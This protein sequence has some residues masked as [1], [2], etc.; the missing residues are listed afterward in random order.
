MNFNPLNSS[1]TTL[2]EL[3][4]HRG[5]SDNTGVHFIN[6]IHKEEFV[7]YRQLYRHALQLL[8][9]FQLHGLRPKDEIV[10]Q[11]D[12]NK[13]FLH[14]F[15]ACILGGFRPVPVAVARHE[16]NYNK[17]RKIIGHLHKPYLLT[18]SELMALKKNEEAGLQALFSGMTYDSVICMD[19]VHLS[20]KA[21]KPHA[22]QPGDIAFIQFSSGSTGDPKGVA[23]THQNIL[24]NVR[25][26]LKSSATLAQETLLTWMPLTHDMGLIGFH[27]NPAALGSNHWIMPTELF[28]R[29]PMLWL[30]K[31]H[32]HR[33]NITAAPSSG[34][35]HLLQK[36]KGEMIDLSCVR[37][38]L[39][40]AEPI[41]ARLCRHFLETLH[42]Y[43]LQPETM[44]P[45][46]G[47]A[48]ATLAVSFPVP[49]KVFTSIHVRPDSLRLFEKIIFTDDPSRAIELV[50]VGNCISC[51]NVQVV[52]EQG[53]VLPE[54]HT[55][56]IFLK[57]ENITAGYYNNAAATQAAFQ[58]GW[59]NTQDTGFMWKGELYIT[60]RVKEL[61]FHKGSNIYPQDIEAVARSAEENLEAV[62]CGIQNEDERTD[63]IILFV[64]YRKE[65]GTFLDLANKLKRQVASKLGIEVDHVIPVKKI[66]LTSS[67]KIKRFEL[68]DNYR[69][70]IYDEVIGA[71]N[72]KQDPSQAEQ[73]IVE[74]LSKRLNIDRHSVNAHVSFADLGV[75]SLMAVEFAQALEA[76]F[77]IHL[78][79]TI[80]WKYPNAKTLA[81]CIAGE[82]NSSQVTINATQQEAGLI[83]IVGMACRFPQANDTAAFWQL[84]RQGVDCISKVPA[85]RWTQAMQQSIEQ[86]A[87]RHT[88]EYGGYLSQVD[89][90][91]PGFFGISPAEAVHMDPQQRLLMEVSW[92]ALEDAGIP[93]HD[94]SGKEAGVFIG[95]SSNDYGRLASQQL[96][97]YT[98]TGNAFSI[99]ANR[100]SYFFNFQGP[101]VAI[102]TACSSSLV[103]VHQACQSLQSGESSICLAG[104]INLLLSPALSMVFSENRML[105]KDGRCKTFDAGADGYVRGEG[106]GIVVLKKLQDAEKDGDRILAVIRGSA[107]NQDGHSNGLTAP[108]PQAQKAVIQKAMRAANVK[109]ADI[110]YVE[111]HGTGTPL[112][113]PI[114]LNTLIE[115]FGEGRSQADPCYIGSVKTN[116]GHLEAAAGIAGL[117][118][119]I[120]LLQHQQ[121]PPHLHLRSMN[122]HIA[123]ASSI[124][125]PQQLIAWAT[126][127]KRMG[128]V[129]SFGFGGTNAHVIVE[130]APEKKLEHNY[131]PWPVHLFVL[132]ATTSTALY[133]LAVSNAKELLQTGN[134]FHDICYTSLVGRT[135]F[136][137]RLAIVA[138]SKEDLV[139][140]L[141]DFLHN[142]DHRQ[143]VKGRAGQVLHDDHNL[144]HHS[145]NNPEADHETILQ[146]LAQSYVQGIPVD[147]KKIYPHHLFRKVSLP[148][149]PFKRER[150]WIEEPVSPVSISV[151]N[152][153]NAHPL[154]GPELNLAP[155][156]EMRFANTT[157]L[158]PEY[159]NHH[160]VYGKVI[161]PASAYIE[162]AL[163]AGA[164]KYAGNLCIENIV[165]EK[166]M[167][168]QAE[169]KQPVQFILSAENNSTASFQLYTE[170]SGPASWQLHCS[171][172]LLKYEPK[173]DV[174]AD[175]NVFR[176]NSEEIPVDALYDSFAAAGITYGADFRAM[177]QVFKGN[178]EALT[179]II[180][181]STLMPHAD[182][183]C[184]HPVL[185]DACFQAIA[186]IVNDQGNS[187]WMPDSIGK[188]IYCN[189]IQTPAW[190][191]ARLR[192]EKNGYDICQ[193]NLSVYDDHGKLCIEVQDL[194]IKKI[195]LA[196][197]F[198]S[199]EDDVA[200]WLYN[201]AW[202]PVPQLQ[203]EVRAL[204]SQMEPEQYA[205]L[206]NTLDK[207][208]VHFMIQALSELGC[209]FHKGAVIRP[210]LFEALK[211]NQ[212]HAR[213]L[214]RMLQ[215][216]EEE[217][218]IEM[219]A[220]EWKVIRAV[221]ATKPGDL[222]KQLAEKFPA[223]KEELSLFGR[224]ASQIAAVLKKETDAL[225]ILFP[226][227]DISGL[228]AFYGESPVA[229]Y[230][231]TLAA[232]AVASFLCQLPAAR[233]INILEIGAGTGATTAAILPHL[234]GREV[235]YCFTDISSLFLQKAQQKFKPYPFISYKTLDIETDPAVAGSEGGE[236]DIIIAAN[237]LHATKDV[238]QSLKHIHSL[239]SCNGL[240][241]LV[242]ITARQ[243]WL[244]LVFGLTDGWWRFE[245][246][247]LRPSHPL[248]T[249]NQ[250]KN[251]L[252]H[253]GFRSVDDLATDKNDTS[254]IGQ[255]VFV[256]HKPEVQ[257]AGKEHW[258]LL[259]DDKGMAIALSQLLCAKQID[260]TLVF[261][262]GEYKQT[263]QDLNSKSIAVKVIDMRALRTLAVTDEADVMQ[264]A[265]LRLC[266]D[267][268][269]LLH[270]LVS[271]KACTLC[272]IT[273]GSQYINDAMNVEGLA[274]SCLA[275]MQKVIAL[276]HPE[277]QCRLIDMGAE[278]YEQEAADLLFELLHHHQPGITAIRKS[279]A[280]S[281]ELIKAQAPSKPC[282]LRKGVYLITGGS[283]GLGITAA[284]KL[285]EKGAS[286]LVLVSRNISRHSQALEELKN[287][288]VQ[289][290][291]A[292]ADVTVKEDL[293]RVLDDIRQT[294]I[295]LRG[296]IH[297]AGILDDGILLHQRTDQFGAV[298]KPKVMGAWN[299]HQLTKNI[300]LDHFILFS[301][302]TALFGSPGQSSHCAANAFLDALAFYRNANG[303]PALSLNWGLWSQTGIVAGD[304][305]ER[306]V[307]KFNWI[308]SIPTTEG[309]DLFYSLMNAD[310]PQ[311]AIMPILWKAL[312][313]S[314]LPIGLQ[315]F[316]SGCMP[317]GNEYSKA[318]KP[319]AGT[320]GRQ[321]QFTFTSD[322][323]PV[324]EYMTATIAE[325]TGIPVT[326]IDVHCPLLNMGMDS[327]LSIELKNYIKKDWN[328]DINLA[329][330]MEG[331]SIH[332]LAQEV[333]KQLRGNSHAYANEQNTMEARAVIKSPTG[334]DAARELLMNIQTIPDE[335]VD[336]LLKQ[337]TANT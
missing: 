302:A 174:Q 269:E 191:H 170:Q 277:L 128:G 323:G 125:V 12:D 300:P 167:V 16:E 327:L 265:T 311:V 6:G 117:I 304:K 270:E 264:L 287:S 237:V 246:I 45:A 320:E 331:I 216:L 251:I 247:G 118:K 232:K 150:Y 19:L 219:N 59:L 261:S 62:A 233:K 34:I 143:V 291:L 145:L 109:P 48:E 69:Q 250:W 290:T 119:T 88:I 204:H 111:A 3:F 44:Y 68:S 60:G 14:G 29:H 25:S 156:K 81:A 279:G 332:E 203:K 146:N 208:S 40:G 244:D 242:E 90:F 255:S 17:L 151:S 115:I 21:G 123:Q 286:H 58:N 129:S 199:G 284:K 200:N 153:K 181:P 297:A 245:D 303:L 259:A 10:F 294:G 131:I 171:G 292:E 139:E 72:R 155:G 175:L 141:N 39:N 234:E 306:L 61:I 158:Y 330:L 133:Q 325:I 1:I 201:V 103:A 206:F 222:V 70:G 105:S 154:L 193:A 84:L 314:M 15:W 229:V 85:C 288:G 309:A 258:L 225:G 317:A 266:T 144:Y 231:N 165:F 47:L 27:I 281:P 217:E 316:I 74:W 324:H 108:N 238:A 4:V 36:F 77:N 136:P 310:A 182:A 76:A 135:H 78:Q 214:N 71:M 260:C 53:N 336:A 271:I 252:E 121:I 305:A 86:R 289:V 138:R 99:A 268:L 65:P 159:L 64:K 52:N 298:L 80:A 184:V 132:S 42:P 35:R 207:A 230:T 95:I 322:D 198:Q 333:T 107:V 38:I 274:Q 137:Y 120:L 82:W 272:I 126:N 102:D 188:L 18:T 213:L 276:E 241:V 235:N 66:P 73:W 312:E 329:R 183:Y 26:S 23:L 285:A 130:E 134:S 148:S 283:G 249:F 226:G 164:K 273:R 307:G 147:W 122:A 195:S 89:A 192:D 301:S 56:Y 179:K 83:A 93:M 157:G 172:R 112:G 313:P 28:V 190:V 7:S 11:L 334:A 149:Y 262:P 50:S 13:S 33:I 116:I 110:G 100:L 178:R 319:E 97:P 168:L 224:C 218:I 220:G 194:T 106:C 31:L 278:A 177:Q 282:A 275:S 94:V 212:A 215:V 189:H 295:P 140:R 173:H 46:Y 326:E 321:E 57:G 263:L 87:D 236:Y 299:L 124:Q 22:A 186:V 160:I 227:G 197:L 196:Q 142:V 79:P 211:L 49:G 127:K 51:C 91:D 318:A 41:S 162:M 5:A 223:A 239:L 32:E 9:Y 114:E 54:G 293:M 335:D 296:I 163:A 253:A 202:K 280:Y 180:L 2:V 55:G 113:D 267:C 67:G 8:H 228:A 43:G 328:V 205:P 176:N 20:S 96:H 169:N 209:S 98:G 63:E 152:E 248:L 37:I 101:S 308:K 185:L 30:Q 24:S 257:A 187:A 166:A 210:A 315:N 337:Y 254:S 256:S 92:E 240:L 161:L 243:K 75:T 221:E 104:G